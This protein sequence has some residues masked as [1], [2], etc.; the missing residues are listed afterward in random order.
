VS[1]TEHH[2]LSGYVIER[3]LPAVLCYVF[4]MMNAADATLPCAAMRVT[5]AP[6]ASV[7]PP[8]PG[9]GAHCAGVRSTIAVRGVVAVNDARKAGMATW[10][11]AACLGSVRGKTIAVLGMTFK[12]E[13]DDM[14][15]APSIPII[16]RLAQ[17]GAV[18]RVFDPKGM[19]QARSILPPGL[20]YCRD[21]MD[22]A[23][24]ADALLLI[25][26]WRME[27]IPCP[28]TGATGRSDAWPDRSRS[29][30]RLRAGRYAPSRVQLSR[31]DRQ[32]RT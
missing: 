28:L 18:L 7:M 2:A 19:D 15:D 12:P 23:T 27:R 31:V 21:A 3:V 20:I 13:T 8:C 25:T 5:C 6:A 16:A 10:V 1:S 14:R 29:A 24:E 4:N 32:S 22:A 9:S 30:Q 26:E 11:I 17:D